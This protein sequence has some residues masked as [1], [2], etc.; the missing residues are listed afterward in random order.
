MQNINKSTFHFLFGGRGSCQS[1]STGVGVTTISN[2]LILGG[3]M[4][5]VEGRSLRDNNTLTLLCYLLDE[6]LPL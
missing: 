6:K 2:A 5:K 4:T 3:W 1:R